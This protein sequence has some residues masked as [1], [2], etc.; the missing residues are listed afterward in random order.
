M[1]SRNNK[2]GISPDESKCSTVTTSKSELKCNSVTSSKAESTSVPVNDELRQQLR[3][4]HRTNDSSGVAAGFYDT[5]SNKSPVIPT[6]LQKNIQ[7]T[8]N[9]VKKNEMPGKFRAGSQMN[10]SS[11]TGSAPCDPQIRR[12]YNKSNDS[13]AVAACFYGNDS[14]SLL[15][16]TY[17]SDMK[18]PAGLPRSRYT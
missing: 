2:L 15:K 18:A 3:Y 17:Q 16:S 12:Y 13:S 8:K 5:N 1:F 11:A 6:V 14:S 7:V 4:S 9:V 10:T